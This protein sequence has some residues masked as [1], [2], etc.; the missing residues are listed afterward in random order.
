MFLGSLN[1][2]AHMKYAG[3]TNHNLEITNLIETT[4]N[5]LVMV[6]I[7]IHINMT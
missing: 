3:I 2:T 1:S 4:G 6:V 5:S 7:I